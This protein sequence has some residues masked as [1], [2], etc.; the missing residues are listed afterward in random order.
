MAELP[1]S[2]KQAVAE[3]ISKASTA[4]RPRFFALSQ[5][6]GEAMEKAGYQ[7]DEPGAPL[8]YA[9]NQASG[10]AN[11]KAPRLAFT[12]NPAPRDNYLGLFKSKR[13]LLPDEVLKQ[14][15]IQDHLVAAILRARGSM[16]SLFGHF[17]KDRF[18]CWRRSGPQERIL[19]HSN[20]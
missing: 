6:A 12:E 4:L 3:A 2:E 11:K 7:A 5:S 15:R 10:S 8:M 20:P 17:K 19:R 18:R 14:I 16:I 1:E 13:R 9:I